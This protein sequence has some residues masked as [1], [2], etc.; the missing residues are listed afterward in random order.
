MHRRKFIQMASLAAAGMLAGCKKDGPSPNVTEGTVEPM[1]PKLT[2]LTTDGKFAI[3]Y[4]DPQGNTRLQNALSQYEVAVVDP[5]FVPPDLFK[6]TMA[7][8]SLVDINTS[9]G[10]EDLQNLL[11]TLHNIPKD[12]Q[13]HDGFLHNTDGSIHLNPGSN[14]TN[15]IEMVDLRNED[16]YAAMFN[17]FATLVSKYPKGIFFDNIDYL[18]EAEND[19]LSAAQTGHPGAFDGNTDKALQLFQEMVTFAKGEGR[20]VIMNGGFQQKLNQDRTLAAGE[21]ILDKIIPYVD[22]IAKEG[23]YYAAPNTPQDEDSVK[24]LKG[25]VQAVAKVMQAHHKTALTFLGNEVCTT[26]QQAT[27]IPPTAGYYNSLFDTVNT[28]NKVTITPS[29]YLCDISHTAPNDVIA[30]LPVGTKVIG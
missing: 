30:N 15:R 26:G 16:A 1:A 10:S 11:N 19:A 4:G 22:T 8:A 3:F 27:A 23:L 5:G 24:W 12:A 2:G 17:Y 29:L 13:G 18:V 28:A 21:P 25:R 9:N 7:Y 6:N 20:Q 14:G